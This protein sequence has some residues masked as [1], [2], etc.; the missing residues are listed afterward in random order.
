MP[1]Y[2]KLDLDIFPTAEQKLEIQTSFNRDIK[3]NG[4]LYYAEIQASSEVS[5]KH[6]KYNFGL[7][8]NFNDGC[9]NNILICIYLGNGIR[10]FDQRFFIYFKR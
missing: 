9:L 4:I 1:V 10:L 5:N 3:D 2:A 6:Q 8:Y 7:K